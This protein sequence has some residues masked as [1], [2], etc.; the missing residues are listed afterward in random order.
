MKL[1]L[2]FIHIERGVEELG[3]NNFLLHTLQRFAIFGLAAAV[4]LSFKTLP[5]PC[6][7]LHTPAHACTVR[8]R[9]TNFAMANRTKKKKKKLNICRSVNINLSIGNA[10]MRC[11]TCR[12]I[13]HKM[14]RFYLGLEP[15][16]RWATQLTSHWPS[17]A[18]THTHTTHT[19]HAA[20][21]THASITRHFLW[22]LPRQRQQQH[23]GEG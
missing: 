11:S 19:T 20:H 13:G 9:P 10:T 12:F 18:P 3:R 23:A 6:T 16:N 2:H 1:K 21:A 22:E 15:C 5:R 17:L 4:A 8:G 7:L 14:M